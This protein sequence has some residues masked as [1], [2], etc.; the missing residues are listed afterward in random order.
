MPKEGGIQWTES[1]SIVS[2]STKKDI[3]KT[4]IQYALS[5]EGRSRSAGMKAY[6]AFC[7]TKA[8]QKALIEKTAG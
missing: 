1:Y 7:V 2:T 4:Y 3:A 8:G 5:P 6:P